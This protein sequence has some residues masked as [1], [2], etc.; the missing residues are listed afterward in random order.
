MFN[1]YRL[2]PSLL[3]LLT[4]LFISIADNQTLLF[5]LSQRLDLSSW[6]GLGYGMTLLTLMVLL[7]SL[8][9]FLIAH[10]FW[11]KPLL[12]LLLLLSATLSYFTQNLGVIFDTDMIRNI[13]ET[14]RDQNQKEA[15][16]LISWA[17]IKHWLLWGIL[18]SL[19]VVLLPVA[20]P[21]TG[22]RYIAE[23]ALYTV[24]LGLLAVGLFV[25]NNQYV[26][27]FSRENNG[28]K[29]Y[30]TPLYA[31][32]SLNNYYQ[33]L[34]AQKTQPFTVLGQDAV[35]QKSHTKRY[36]G[37]MVLGETARADHFSLNG[38]PRL[39]NP[40]LSQE[41]L[42]SFR[43]MKACGTSTAYSVPCMFSFLNQ[44]NYTPEQADIQS[45]V[46]DVLQQAGVKVV[47]IDNNSSCKG[48]CNRI[49]NVNLTKQGNQQH[50]LYSNGAYYDE[51][52]LEY[53]TPYLAGDEDVLL[54]LH[55]LGSHGPAYHLRYPPEFAQFKPYCQQDT[56]HVCSRETVVNSYDNTLL[57]TD[58]F[59]SKTI[60]WLKQTEQASQGK[61][62]S[63]LLYA[64][65]HGESLGENGIYLH[66]LPYFLAPTA[67]THVPALIWLSPN[68]QQQFSQH[69]TV[70]QQRINSAISHDY[71]THTLL[72]FY[73]V[74]TA[75]YQASLDL[76]KP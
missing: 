25:L 68:Y 67:Q 12:I 55:S 69:K 29:V 44:A 2:S 13:L 45:N 28:L 72:G 5:E 3:I 39:T 50:A 38:Y 10:A 27:F 34:A 31:L 22:K 64:S 20:S 71:L 70:L 33:G 11:L 62:I 74:K 61:I 23:R 26:T 53:L 43:Q 40:L 16:E 47:W 21:T 36:V 7:L 19:I 51:A 46:L 4:V 14:W 8:P 17:L 24:G 65:D 48:V 57:Y 9:L 18:P 66:G 52:M 15:T 73:E 60:Q 32:S 76:L 35:Q 56:P 59:L 6:R 37:I 42:V 75:L 1:H 63:F 49:E 30:I 54:V 58:Y 41:D